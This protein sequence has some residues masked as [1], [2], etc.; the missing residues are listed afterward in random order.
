MKQK[1]VLQADLITAIYHELKSSNNKFDKKEIHVVLKAILKT[2]FT[3]LSEDAAKK[4][5]EEN[6]TLLLRLQGI[7]SLSVAKR[8]PA[9]YRIP[10]TGAVVEKDETLRVK[11]MPSKVLK[12]KVNSK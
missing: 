1:D 3:I 6:L 10:S 5:K 11:F 8:K 9:S 12:E 7:G 4:L 2:M